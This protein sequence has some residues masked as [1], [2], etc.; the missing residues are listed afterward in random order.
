MAKYKSLQETYLNGD[1]LFNFG[2]LVPP[3]LFPNPTPPPS[4]SPTGTP[5]LSPTPTPSITATL[6]PTPTLTSTPTPTNTG[7]PTPT[8]TNTGTPT[9]T[10]TN[11]ATPTP[12]KTGTPTPTPTI[13]PTTSPAVVYETGLVEVECLG[14]I[15]N[16][17]DVVSVNGILYPI[18]I[19]GGTMGNAGC[20]PLPIRNG[21]AIIY[22]ITYGAG[23]SVCMTPGNTYD[24]VRLINFTYSDFIFPS[25][26]YNYTE[27]LYMGGVLIGSSLKQTRKIAPTDLGAGCPTQT[28]NLVV[29]FYV[30]SVQITPYPTPTST[31]TPTPTPTI[32][33][34]PV[35]P[36]SLNITS[37][38]SA[39]I[40][41][42]TY[43][44]ATIGSGTTFDYGYLV[45]TG[46]LTGYFVFGTA[47]DGNNYPIF[48]YDSGDTN[49]LY[50]KFNGSTDLGWWG[51][52]QF[53]NPLTSGNLSGAG[54]QR[55]FGFDY[56]DIGG[57]RFIKA[58]S[59]VGGSNP[60][61]IY[62]E[63][64]I[65]CPTPTPTSTPTNTATPTNTPTPSSSPSVANY[66]IL[67]E[68]GDIITA[69]NGD[70]IE[71]QH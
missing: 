7:T 50:R 11:T 29:N 43:T 45:E 10:P 5:V 57:I 70:G 27:Q 46:G 61:L 6:T 44:R 31:K 49:V 17:G 41:V 47:P 28:L 69:Q 16:A 60:A 64:P 62:V 1:I 40:D 52:E 13:T 23:N 33:P 42:A 9:N 3:I 30:E 59:N 67:A 35:C 34:N 15:L 54:G 21:S 65:A 24:E 37:S 56:T 71:Y 20:I 36:Q 63:Y 4:P 39:I 58:G 68:N 2:G 55:S 22:Q 26:G 18:M 19:S 12:T 48:Q 14:G 53:P 38:N 8:P 66:F 32:T 25:G 51:V